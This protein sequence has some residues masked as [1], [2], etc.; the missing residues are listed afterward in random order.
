MLETNNA[1]E[2]LIL[3]DG[4]SYLYRAFHAMPP[5]TNGSGEPTGA[6]YGVINMVKKLLKEYPGRRFAVVFDAKG[7]TFRNDMYDQYKATRPP[8]PDELRPQIE[9]IHNIIRAM[10][11]PIIVISGVEADDVIGTLAAQAEKD[12][13]EVVIS[14]GDKD[15]AQLVTEKVT[16]LNTMNDTVLDIPGVK[17]KFGIPPELI[18]DYLALVGDK[19]DNIPGVEKVGPKTA[20]KWL[21]KYGSVDA[22]IENAAEIGGK[23][24]E[25]LRNGIEQLQLSRELVTIKLDVVDADNGDGA[26][27]YKDILLQ[28]PDVEKLREL[29]KKCSFSTWLSE[30]EHPSVGG[31]QQTQQQA[32][33][34]VVLK[35]ED[36]VTLLGK[37]CSAELIAFDVETTS[38]NY[39]EAELVGIS[40]AVAEGAA[41]YIPLGHD[42]PGAP[43]QLSLDYVLN[44]L[45]G[46]LAS[47]Q[48]KK[49]GHNLKYDINV[50]ARYDIAVNNIA[51]D[52]MLESYVINSTALRHNMDAVAQYYL[53]YQTIHYEEVAGKGAKQIGFNQ[54]S[55]EEATPYAAEDADISLRIH[56]R[57][58]S[59]IKQSESQEQIYS[60]IEMK[61]LPVLSSMERAGVLINRDMLQQ[62]SGVLASRMLEL[63]E[64]A[65]QI[66]G[67]PFNLDS[68]KQLQEILFEKQ[69]IPVKKKT[70]KGAP[71]T[72][73]A[74]LVELAED[75]E[76]PAVI[77]EHRSLS[78]IKSTYTEKLPRLINQ[79]TGRVH[80]SYHQAVTA[81]GRLSSSDP[82]L[83]NIPIKS[84]EGRRVRQAFTAPENHLIMAADYSQI[85][86]RIMAHISGDKGLL[87]AF[88]EGV[89]IHK[90]TAAEVFATAVDSVSSNQRRAAKAINFGLVYG[91]S[92]FGLSKQLNIGRNEAQEY[93]DLYFGRYPGVK[94][95]IETTRE[96]ARKNGYVETIMGRRLYIPDINSKNGQKRQYAERAAINAPMQGTAADII[97][98]AMINVFDQINGDTSINMTMQVHDELVFE[99]KKEKLDELSQKVKQT[100]E[101]VLQLKVP[102]VVDVG[103][104]ANWEEAH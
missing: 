4:S 59:E 43:E 1:G 23:V 19:S 84:E 93:I 52:S 66:A 96:I 49:V 30:L 6:V 74:V 28:E 55:I 57:L 11:V 29:Y 36:F 61:L 65:Y 56:N 60:Q 7:K 78:K 69:G 79:H 50:L 62:Q 40:F 72:A 10:G 87:Q 2:K 54:V 101:S 81:T 76:L 33:Y 103:F 38:L 39:M 92:A 18:I 26:I 85:E 25:N 35:N 75:Y 24:G 71:S 102:L 37:L 46:I 41:Y 68:P 34:R 95:Y 91:M 82:N 44:E 83:Q 104:G 88:N 67:Q 63:E 53:D 100:M 9:P 20:V 15:L 77:I 90:A 48:I 13:I 51:Y 17:E 3:V 31:S 73:E 89:D 8:M 45:K 86:L 5:L 42:Y 98:M 64:K 27:S 94:E 22:I 47:E 80:T 58:I 21:E 97:K 99:V 16:L 12:S 70:P 32:E 14:T